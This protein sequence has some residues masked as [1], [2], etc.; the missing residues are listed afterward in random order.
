MISCIVFFYCVQYYQLPFF[1]GHRFLVID[2]PTI[3]KP[4][5]QKNIHVSH[6]HKDIKYDYLYPPDPMSLTSV[7]CLDSVVH[8]VTSVMKVAHLTAIDA[9]FI[10][11]ANPGSLEASIQSGF[12]SK[13]YWLGRYKALTVYEQKRFGSGNRLFEHIKDKTLLLF[14]R[15]FPFR[16]GQNGKWKVENSI[17]KREC[18]PGWYFLGNAMWFGNSFSPGDVR[19]DYTYDSGYF[20]FKD[21]AKPKM[22]IWVWLYPDLEEIYGVR[23][24]RLCL[25]STYRVMGLTYITYVPESKILKRSVLIDE[26]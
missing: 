6:S 3:K 25:I 4:G 24:L 16:R 1:P 23:E 17:V 19:R 14:D 15:S 22:M 11:V 12:Y 21:S 13:E 10:V 20:M 7:F 18:G 8:Q 9:Q 26:T 2:S 5:F